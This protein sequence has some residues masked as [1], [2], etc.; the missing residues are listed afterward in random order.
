MTRNFGYGTRDM[1]TAARII[2][3]LAVESKELSFASSD[4][5]ADRFAHF[6]GYA[7]K[8]GFG[9]MERI[10]FDLVSRYGRELAAQVIAGNLSPAYA[11]NLVSAVNTVMS[12]GSKG[13]WQSVSP[14]KDCHIPQRNAIR[15]E[16]PGALSRMTYTK[17][18][19]LVREKLGD[20]IASVI[21]LARDFGLRSKEASLINSKAA[22]L[23]ARKRGAVTISEG[24]KG[25]LRRE[26]PITSPRQLE[27]LQRAAEAQGDDRSMIPKGKTWKTWREQDLRAARDLV[28][29]HTGGGLHDLRA[30]YACERYEALTGLASPVAGG[31]ITDREADRRARETIAREM[32]HGRIDVVG[33]YVGGR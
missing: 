33:E 30:A 25:G 23:G 13:E 28:S 11:Q 7:K 12:L 2:T 29:A 21:E 15:E 16:V 4:V 32:G 3:N 1:A 24:S 17:A 19:E 10:N 6:A 22:L 31:L 27:T 8:N 26:I 18:E 14:T 20:R 9:R 5:I